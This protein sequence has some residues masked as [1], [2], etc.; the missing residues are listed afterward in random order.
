[1][2]EWLDDT[3]MAAWR[4]LLGVHADVL[5]ELENDLVARHGVTAGDYAVLVALSEAP[6]DHLRM[7]DLAAHLHLSPSGLTR[8]LDGLV[9]AGLVAREPSSDD[10]RVILAVLT[11]EGRARLDAAAPDH[12]AGVRQAFL[13]HLDPAQVAALADACAAVLQGRAQRDAAGAPAR[14]AA[15]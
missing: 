8:R 13:D 15:P 10:R 2:T 6:G 7:C 1:M 9:K 11:S 4:G 14:A 12:V 5:A 3:E